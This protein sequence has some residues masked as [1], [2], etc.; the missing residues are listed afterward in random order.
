[1]KTFKTSDGHEW[2]IVVNV[3][4]IRRC[5]HETGLTLTD[6]FST[7]KKVAE[8]F[9]DDVRFS[10]VLLS[11]VRP[12]LAELGKTD[13]DFFT[14]IDGSVIESAAE[15]LLAEVADFFQEPRKGLLKKA[16]KKFQEAAARVRNEEIAAVEKELDK[17]DF[18]TL[19]HQTHT[20]SV[21]SSPVSAA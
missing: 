1:M 17:M 7:E 9:A 19:I 13:D 10:E 2:S 5:M 12:Q 6:L 15:A 16:M 11:V 20:S 21:S 4:T 8:F 3:G 18:Q 14:A